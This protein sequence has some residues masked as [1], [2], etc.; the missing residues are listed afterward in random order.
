MFLGDNGACGWV[1]FLVNVLKIEPD[2]ELKRYHI[3]VQPNLTA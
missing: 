3:M 2:I 1:C